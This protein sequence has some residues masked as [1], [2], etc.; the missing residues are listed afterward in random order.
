MVK[1]YL[2]KILIAFVI[3]FTSFIPLAHIAIAKESYSD[4]FIK[5][6]DA[7][8]ALKNNDKDKAKKLIEEF[9]NEF[10][11]TKNSDSE[12]GKRVK[13]T[14]LSENLDEDQLREL[15]T[16]LLAFETE[17]N[18]ID[19]EA[20]K[21]AFKTKLYPSFDKLE[22]AIDTKDVE[23]MK[24][25]YVKYN[26]A[27]VR[28][29]GIVR[30]VEPA[31]YG[32][33][34][35]TMSFLRSSMEVEP[36]DYQTTKMYLS[37]LKKHLDDFLAG[38]K[39]EQ[40]S[41]VKT[42]DQGIK[43]LE[44]S[45]NAFV[46]GD[47]AQ[48][49]QKMKKFIEV[50]PVIEGDVRTRNASLY[51]KVESETPIIMVKG[52]EQKYQDQL[53]DL[54]A[55]LSKI[56]T[57]SNYNAIDSMLILLREGVEALV[58][59]LS[60][61]SALRAA[62]QRKGLVWVYAGAISGILA[63]ILAAVVLKYSFPALSSGTNREIIEGVV[64]IFAVI[65]MI[66]IGIWLHSKSSVKAWKDYMD[67]KLNVVLS[68]GS[69]VS[70]F[71]LSF[72]AVFRE[73]AETILFYAGIM[74]LITTSNLLIGI[75]LAIVALIILGFAMMKASGKLPISKVFLVLSWLIY[76]L[77]FKMLG[78]SI[79]A[80]QITDMLSNHIID[81]MP[82]IEWLGIYPSYEVVIS[83]IVYMIIVI[84]SMIYEKSKHK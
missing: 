3:I 51:T 2:S 73:G 7:N 79:H 14:A 6:T 8:T 76:I 23:T 5:I 48:G 38:K 52:N 82:T 47:K 33:I 41:D 42:L 70:M 59:V 61:A 63:S 44:E 83:Q 80:L 49:S 60:L 43:L 4:L 57:K 68:T 28:N 31:Y 32:K 24:A 66:G 37:D 58:I 22:K 54:I 34:E 13:K 30:S 84:L 29:E 20:E 39:L 21:K 62:K 15:S 12:A 40:N 74:P 27:W 69:F 64:G 45:Y 65:M 16:A 18:P 72:L 17:Q 71:A 81:H 50:W 10:N 26:A 11:A 36:Y 77:G 55:E 25:E 1:N 9:R 78:V 19:I 67:K 53:K 35:T 46:S 56:D 75:G